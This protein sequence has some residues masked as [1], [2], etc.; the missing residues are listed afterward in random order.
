MARRDSRIMRPILNCPKNRTNG[1]VTAKCGRKFQANGHACGEYA[2]SRGWRVDVRSL[3]RPRH[4]E[5]ASQAAT[6]EPARDYFPAKAEVRYAKQ[7]RITYHRY[8]K[9]VDFNPTVP[10]RERLQYLLVQRGAPV[11]SGYPDAQIVRVPVTRYVHLHNAYFGLLERF[12]LLDGLVGINSINGVTV[13]PIL[14]G[15]HAGRIRETGAGNHSNIEIAI[16]LTPRRS[17]FSIPPIWNTTSIQSCANSA[18]PPC[19]SPISSSPLR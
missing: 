9:V 4:L 14:D 16:G 10:T 12:A 11:P 7:F 15:H 5:P 13:Q 1:K 3:S 17:F 2:G 18:S 8:Y 6:S 19:N